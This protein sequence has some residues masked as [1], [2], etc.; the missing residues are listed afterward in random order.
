MG[1]QEARRKKQEVKVN[2]YKSN[3]GYSKGPSQ[4]A[5]KQLANKNQGLMDAFKNI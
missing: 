2:N 4:Q 5:Y 1:K 3:N